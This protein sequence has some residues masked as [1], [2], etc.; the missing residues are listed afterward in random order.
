VA[1][2]GE[3]L[4]GL[5]VR[6]AEP[7]DWQ[8]LREVRL[9][10]LRDAPDAFYA[11]YEQT[12]HRPE[13]DW[14][15][16]PNRG[17]GFL[18][19]LAGEPVGMVGVATAAADPARADLFAMW[20]APPIRGSGAADALVAAALD[21]AREHGCASVDLEVAPGND[22]AERLYARHGFVP[23]GEP[24]VIDC[25]LAMRLTFSQTS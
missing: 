22:R 8:A 16:W 11:T 25:G 20:V 17:V 12:V 1:V 19:W 13:A 15:A 14:R 18:A 2:H 6:V 9:A 3:E 23:S 24:T 10:A 5:A 21:W 7:D 4:M